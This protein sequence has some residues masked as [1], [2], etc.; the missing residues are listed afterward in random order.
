MLKV[1]CNVGVAFTSAA[2]LPHCSRDDGCL[3]L[4]DLSCL[5]LGNRLEIY[6]SRDGP[7]NRPSF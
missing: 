5:A 2:G 6:I 4:S 3:S 7:R 1:R